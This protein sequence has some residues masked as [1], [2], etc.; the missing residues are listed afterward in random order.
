M[1]AAQ[2]K[3]SSG[4]ATMNPEREPLTELEVE[5]IARICHE[6]NRAYCLGLG[7]ASQLPWAEAPEWQ[8]QSAR[9]GVRHRIDNQGRPTRYIFN[10]D[11]ASHNSWMEEK[12]RAGWTYGATK[13]P[14]KRRHPCL[15]PYASLP[16]EERRKDALFG[17]VCGA[18]DPRRAL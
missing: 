6:A 3:M 7:D 16:P 1:D 4:Q 14:E 17:A 2:E 13:D 10:E 15:L 8:K 5:N 12:L 18:V 9:N 11:E